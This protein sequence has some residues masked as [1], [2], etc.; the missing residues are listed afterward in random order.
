[1]SSK[2]NKSKKEIKIT[3]NSADINDTEYDD[4]SIGDEPDIDWNDIDELNIDDKT[5]NDD[6]TDDD[7]DNCMYNKV[8]IPKVKKN[9]QLSLA[10]EYDS[11]VVTDDDADD[12]DDDDEYYGDE[13]ANNENKNNL[14]IYIKKED[15]CSCNILTK[16]EV[17]RLLGD[18]I[19]QLSSG[20]KPMLNGVG[21][22]Q[23]RMIAQLELEAKMIPLK[24]VRPL[25]N[26]MKEIWSIDELILKDIYIKYGFEGGKVNREKLLNRPSNIKNKSVN[27]Y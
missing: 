12:D 6:N 26:G 10:N 4:I 1:M 25:P 22:L 24:I 11:I 16:Y 19:S 8:H 14:D 17:V 18:R 15:R 2:T 7:D 5:D 3:E 27:F 23:A 20:A 9:S 13:N 21:G